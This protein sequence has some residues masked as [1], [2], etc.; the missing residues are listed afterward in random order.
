MNFYQ[1]LDIPLSDLTLEQFFIVAFIL[2]VCV[3][4]TVLIFL[5]IYEI[6]SLLFDLICYLLCKD[7]RLGGWFFKRNLCRYIGALKHQTIKAPTE[8]AYYLYYNRLV[9]A[10][11]ALSNFGL[12]DSKLFLKFIS[13]PSYEELRSKELKTK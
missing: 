2:L 4:F 5:E 9:G 7:K 1:F 12:I 8:K 6:L 11:E 3:A 13:I 10:V